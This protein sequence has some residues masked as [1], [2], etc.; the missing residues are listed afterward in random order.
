VEKT[1]TAVE[2]TAR[3][4][5][6]R[7]SLRGYNKN[8]VNAYLEEIN[9]KFAS[10]EENYKRT[11]AAQKQTIESLE[12]K[13]ESYDL[14]RAELDAARRS[15]AEK[16]RQ[17]AEQSKK[18][19]DYESLLEKQSE[20]IGKLKEDKAALEIKLADAAKSSDAL[21]EEC[22]TLRE[23]LEKKEMAISEQAER[24]GFLEDEIERLRQAEGDDV[25]DEELYKK[26]GEVL[27][28]A[29]LDADRMRE[30]GKADAEK[31]RAQA[32]IEAKELIEKAKE[33]IRA[34]R[35]EARAKL[36]EALTRAN[37][38]LVEMGEE[39]IKGYAEYLRA[40]QGDFDGILEKVR[41]HSQNVKERIESLRDII[42][43]ELEKEYGRISEEMNAETVLEPTDSEIIGGESQA[44]EKV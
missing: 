27:V 11:I 41:E 3:N 22:K 6:F 40:V 5:T 33:E 4:V 25:N 20:A 31:I 35:K 43:Q 34:M 23:R 7:E 42:S 30:S 1:G 18:I 9:L 26:V 16:D 29:K 8:D 37:R 36:E 32:E 10:A 15:L 13:L 39:Y 24:I 21:A 2:K 14:I 17:L 38:K 28:V 44:N 19:A 12:N